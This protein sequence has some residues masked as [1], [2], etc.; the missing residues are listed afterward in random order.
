MRMAIWPLVTLI[1]M[2]LSFEIGRRTGPIL[3]LPA[4]AATLPGAAQDFSREFEER[5]RQRFPVG[6]NE[7]ALIGHLDGEGFAPD[8]PRR[9]EPYAAIFV[10]KGLFCTDTLRVVWRTETTGNLTQIGGAYA[11]ECM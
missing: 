5:L 6:T 2:G 1:L 10:R 7:G 3:A 11:S 4:M 9:N 8:W